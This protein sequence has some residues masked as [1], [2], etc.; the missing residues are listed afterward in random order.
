MKQALLAIV[1][2][3]AALLAWLYWPGTPALSPLM[4]AEQPRPVAPLAA[5]MPGKNKA[6][7][8]TRTEVTDPGDVAP[9]GEEKKQTT[10][11]TVQVVWSDDQRPLE[12]AVVSIGLGGSYVG[13]SDDLT[14]STDADGQIVFADIPPGKVLIRVLRGPVRDVQVALDR[15]NTVR[16]AVARGYT[17][18][19]IV[20][21]GIDRPVEGAKVLLSERWHQLRT[22]V[23]ATTSRDG[24]FEIE[25]IMGSRMITANHI[26]LGPARMYPIDSKA[27]SE[28]FVRI[29]L[30]GVAAT[31]KGH[32]FDA[33]G[34]PVVSA[35][36]LIGDDRDHKQV[37]HADG[38][39][40]PDAP[41]TRVKSDASGGFEVH[42]LRVGAT[43]VR[44]SAEGFG[45]LTKTVV[46]PAEVEWVL[47]AEAVLT[48][49]VLD[50][51]GQAVAYARVQQGSGY[52]FGDR[53]AFANGEGHYRLRGLATGELEIVVHGRID[54]GKDNPVAVPASASNSEGKVR[55]RRPGRDFKTKG[56]VA[57][58]AGQ[59]TSWNPVLGR[60]DD[61]ALRGTLV[62]H[63][64]EPLV[65]WL[66]A[67][68]SFERTPWRKNTRT[69]GK[70][71]FELT[72]LEADSL[73]VL[74][75]PPGRWDVFPRVV[76]GPVDRM[77]GNL[78][79]TVPDPSTSLGNLHLRVLDPGGKPTRAKL[80][81]WHEQ[82]KT[83]RS[84][85]NDADTGELL[86]EGIPPGTVS[87]E[88]RSE[89]HPWIR[90]GEKLI[91]AGNTLELGPIVFAASARMTGNLV[92]PPDIDLRTLNM[93]VFH[94]KGSEACAVQ[95]AGGALQSTALAEGDYEFVMQGAGIAPV[96]RKFA[97]AQGQNVH[98]DIAVQRAPSAR[99]KIVFPA[100]HALQ[101]WAR[102]HVRTVAGSLVWSGGAR[103]EGQDVHAEFS[104]AAGRYQVSVYTDKFVGEKSIQ[105]PLATQQITEIIMKPR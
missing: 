90:L 21:D 19:G 31:L 52:H 40:V 20:V 30:P 9:A 55:R 85:V 5:E 91:T 61:Q 76:L 83:W 29:V 4:Q 18:R 65:N 54:V 66:V 95:L 43:T 47:P 45:L 74:V 57:L 2:V 105:V 27:G 93:R 80:T 103:V 1:V 87:L 26:R 67:V 44:I 104:V 100:A 56:T 53:M 97:I 49:T 17:V 39:Y 15:E 63:N 36:L 8:G 102:V 70:G 81:L 86:I 12:G 41:P 48:G 46:L 82:A 10:S 51:L 72:E 96:R 3:C 73:R 11:V 64:G 50:T 75:M 69:D 42:A 14:E 77:V 32:V 99:L 33:Q 98:F 37:M 89:E 16:I 92:G 79:I 13:W 28:Q 62:D 7:P 23:I 38:S 60:D 78:L 88:L 34:N 6:D 94:A 58:H 68:T 25:G 35:Q 22:R 101:G 59:E 71:Q 84:I 24:T